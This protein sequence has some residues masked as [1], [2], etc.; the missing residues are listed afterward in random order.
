M[1]EQR[2]TI[3]FHHVVGDLIDNK[4][5]VISYT[6]SGAGFRQGYVTL[7]ADCGGDSFPLISTY[8]AEPIGTKFY[9]LTDFG[10]TKAKVTGYDLDTEMYSIKVKVP[11]EDR[12]FYGAKWL[13]YGEYRR[14]QLFKDEHELIDYIDKLF[15]PCA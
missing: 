2:Q 3:N 15:N 7:T 12:E 6:I 13:D 8:E 5:G 4:D 9:V 1:S 14:N 11:K 10:V